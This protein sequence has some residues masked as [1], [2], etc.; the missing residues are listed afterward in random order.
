MFKPRR[1]KS[2]KSI[3]KS[4]VDPEQEKIRG[5]KTEIDGKLL[6]ILGFLEQV[7]GNDD[8]KE[9]IRGLLEDFRND[10]ESLYA[11]YDHLTKE[12]K[13]EFYASSS[14]SSDSSDSD[15]DSPKENGKRNGEV[16]IKIGENGVSEVDE[17]KTK[18]EAAID[19]KESVNLSLMSKNMEAIQLDE[20][21]QRLRIKSSEM[22]KALIEK[23]DEIS[24]LNKKCEDVENKATARISALTAYGNSRQEQVGSLG[25]KISEANAIIKKQSA[26]LS[27]CLINIEKLTKGLSHAEKQNSALVNNI[28]EYERKMIAAFQL[29]VQFKNTEEGLK[30]SRKELEQVKDQ[31]RKVVDS[32]NQDINDLEETIVNQHQDILRLEK[33]IEDLKTDL[34]IKEDEIST[35]MEN[36]STTEVKQRL[37]F[38]KLRITEHVLADKEDTYRKRVET[39][40][41]EKRFLEDM[42]DSM[43]ACMEDQV[44]M[45]SEVCV[46]MNE[47]MKGIDTFSVKFEEDFGHLESRIYE[48]ANELKV[49][50]KWITGKK[51]EQD[52]LKQEIARLV[53]ELREDKDEI[54]VLTTKME[55]QQEVLQNGYDERT[56]LN[57]I[58]IDGEE[59]M[60]E[61]EK[62]IEERDEQM[63]ELER[64]MREKDHEI[65]SLNDQK[66]QVIKQLCIGIDY[67]QSCYNDLKDMVSKAKGVRM[68]DGA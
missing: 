24:T 38:Q 45:A 40:L 16:G 1:R 30:A 5:I 6:K 37:T 15:D 61:L 68:H 54:F 25:V 11:C 58:M 53:E 56:R 28:A 3:V 39:L 29:Q 50:T 33:N 55:V 21:N 60:G 59:K 48:I 9:P 22:E 36:M 35:L 7:D 13:E 65:L 2:I 8:K 66:R 41:E 49:V 46:K 4:H 52:Q 14:S 23:E 63:G 27:E 43:A 19:E 32:K 17:L 57:Q 67:Y 42:N 26:Q 10:C 44:R 20:E 31:M 12:L 62:M 47:T 64:K 18:L 51:T 34:E